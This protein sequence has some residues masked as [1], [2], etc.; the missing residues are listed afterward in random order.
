MDLLLVQPDG[1]GRGNREPLFYA[2]KLPPRNHYHHF[3][4]ACLGGEMTE[5]HFGQTAPMTE[6][7]LLG[8]VAIEVSGTILEWKPGMVIANVKKAQ[9]LLQRTYRDGWKVAGL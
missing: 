3:I 7:I 8:T 5:S 4:D 9:E 1:G 2:K 6:A